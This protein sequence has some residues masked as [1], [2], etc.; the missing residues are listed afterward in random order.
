MPATKAIA[1][2][3]CILCGEHAVVYGRPAIAIPIHQLQVKVVI[4][5][6]LRAQSGTITID[7]PE[8]QLH[9]SLSD[10]PTQ[11]PLNIAV[12]LVQQEFNLKSLPAMAIRITSTIPVAAGMG[13]SAA[14]AVALIKAVAEFIGHPLPIERISLLAFEVEKQQHGT[15]SGIDNT[16]IAYAQPIYYIKGQ[17]IVPIKLA[18]LFTLVIADTGISSATQTTVAAVRERWEKDPAAVNELMD[19]IGDIV[20]HVRTDIE[21]GDV[22]STGSH[23]TQNHVL[24]QQLGVSCPALDRL[25]EVSLN[26]GALGAKLTG[27]GGGGHILALVQP[28][29]VEEVISALLTAGASSAFVTT[30]GNQ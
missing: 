20:N 12:Q 9:S 30:I 27:G 24:L 21:T 5:P 8:I 26:H 3:K 25:V 11:H 28:Q 18:A 17:P 15:P 14:V 13:S 7:A 29:Q 22:I 1:P 23:L 19:R 6:D 2:G 10:L 4:L 16:T